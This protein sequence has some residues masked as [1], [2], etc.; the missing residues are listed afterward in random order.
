M[1]Y[2]EDEIL[3]EAFNYIKSTYGQHYAGDQ[4]IQ[5]FDYWKSLGIMTPVA[6]GTA[7]KYLA[8][9]GKKEGANRKDLLKALHYTVLAMHNE[10]Y[11]NPSHDDVD[12]DDQGQPV[13]ESPRERTSEVEIDV[14]KMMELLSRGGVAYTGGAVNNDRT[15]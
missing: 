1:K 15:Q 5:L 14:N 13:M 6:V 8:R 10:F 12:S 3:N 7:M 4:E 2:N 9:F 11:T